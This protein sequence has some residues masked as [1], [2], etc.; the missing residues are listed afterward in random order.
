MYFPFKRLAQYDSSFSVPEYINEGFG[1][2]GDIERK[3]RDSFV[4][5]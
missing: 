2:Q 5:N 1:S 3:I 4:S